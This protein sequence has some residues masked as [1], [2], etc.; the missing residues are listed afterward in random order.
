MCIV[1]RLRTCLW[2]TC[3]PDPEGQKKLL[4]PLKLE[5][6]TEVRHHVGTGNET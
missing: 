4:D 1:F 2:T 6:K 3:T 5:L